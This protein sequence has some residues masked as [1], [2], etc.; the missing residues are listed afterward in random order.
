MIQWKTDPAPPLD[1]LERL[2][3][4]GAQADIELAF[5]EG[6]LVDYSKDVVGDGNDLEIRLVLRHKS[7]LP[8]RWVDVSDLGAPDYEEQMDVDG[9]PIDPACYRHRLRSPT[10]LLQGAWVQGR[11]PRG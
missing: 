2:V 8:S 6:V 1:E 7:A 4:G 9:E 10:N 3:N 5:R 11:A